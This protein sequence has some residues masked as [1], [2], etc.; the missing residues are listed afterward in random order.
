MMASDNALI[1]GIVTHFRPSGPF[2]SARATAHLDLCKRHIGGAIVELGI[3][4]GGSAALL[5]LLARPR[6]LVALELDPTPVQALAELI[7]RRALAATVHPIYGVNQ[8]DRRR[9]V[10]I[11]DDR[12]GDDALDLVIDD[13]SHLL[14]E[15]TASI[16]TLFPYLRSG[17][18]ALA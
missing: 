10:E 9:L 5:S 2:S 3:A 17:G 13:A 11:V 15:T 7:K 12:F 14:P 16:E 6:R 1:E 18:V 8:A 4:E